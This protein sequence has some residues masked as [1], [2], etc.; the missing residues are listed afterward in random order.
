MKS[1]FF[2]LPTGITV[3]NFLFTGVLDKL[4]ARQDLCVV[5]I[6]GLPE[7][8]ERCPVNSER[9]T[10]ERLPCRRSCTFAN[11]LHAVL[12]R[13]FYRLNETASLKIFLKGPLS[14]QYRQVLL[15]TI[16][17]QPLSQS[18][19]IYRWL[20]VLEGHLNSVSTPV[21]ELFERFRPTMVVSTHP[22]AMYEYELLKYARMMGIASVGLIKSWDNLTTKGYIAVPPDYYLVWNE[23]IKD[24]VRSLYNVPNDHVGITGI[25]QFDLYADTASA[26]SREEFCAAMKLDPAKKTI[27][28][29]TSAPWI[30]REDPE[31]VRR[32]AVALAECRG[33]TLQILVRLHP[34]DTLERYWGVVHPSLV[35]HVPGA[36]IGKGADQRL[37]D[38]A[39]IA[40]MRDTF[41]YA[42]VVINTCST[43]TLDAIAMDRPVVNIAFDL[44]PKG[45]YKSSRRYYD[46]DHFQ[47]II[48]L[49]ATRIASSFEELVSMN[50][51]Y[52]DN[53]ELESLERR[54]LRETMCYR[55]DGQSGQRV[56]NYL[57]HWLD[58]LP[59]ATNGSHTA[60]VQ[61]ER[62]QQ[63]LAMT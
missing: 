6:T 40:E 44:E 30:N 60:A 13:R 4:L 36:K 7:V 63:S 38:P 59:C 15:E 42:D 26:P 32:L 17:S 29:A 20:R 2:L 31:I 52:L 55:L 16:L 19:T 45:Y 33:G 50:L 28:Y 5:A 34:L 9:L 43:M 21:R 58:R 25:A 27:L 14:G 46:L 3:R 47:P 48:K 11:L 18:R 24:E 22:T 49:G 62:Q 53:R 10:F 23:I 57:L 39:F 8:F 37:L 1:I 56:A 12:R 41:L 35:F 51:R 54:R 61:R